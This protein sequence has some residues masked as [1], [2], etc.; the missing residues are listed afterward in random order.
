MRRLSVCYA[1]PGHHLVPTAGGTRNVLS[2][3]AA[4]SRWVELTVAFRSIAE[5]VEGRPYRLLALEPAAGRAGLHDDEAARGLNPFPHLGYLRRLGAF[6]R[7]QAGAYDVVLE[8]GWRLSGVLAA[9]FARHGVPAVLVEN[10]LRT[11]PRPEPGPRALARAGLDL[12]ARRLVRARCRRLPAIAETEELKAALV[13]GRGM[14]PEQVE[15]VALGVDHALFH[16]RDQ[17][18]ARAVLGIDPGATVLLYAGGLDRYHDLAPVIRALG[19]GRRP[20]LQ[21]HVVGDGERRGEAEALARTAGA[22]A[23]FH[24][25][26]AHE[27]VPVWIAAADLCL[28]PY[29][30]EAFPRAVVTFSTLKVPEYMACARPVAT[31]P[32]GAPGR[33]VRHGVAGFLVPNEP[34]AWGRLLETLPER[35]RLAE[36]GRA[37]AQAVEVLSWEATARAYLAVCE[38]AVE[39]RA[40]R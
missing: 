10:D 17:A 19:A 26:T 14:A 4:L 1:A 30:V 15:V 2:V 32:G 37:A 11:G 24:G 5:A 9:A 8:K 12:L 16:P 25:R 33:L 21:L 22:R 31:V 40:G 23:R 35:G 36:M 28:A 20:A 29:R 3:A 34:A 6:A 27:T 13:D 7:A 38:R 39:G 18:A